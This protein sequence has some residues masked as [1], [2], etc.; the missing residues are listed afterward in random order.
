MSLK[1]RLNS[2]Q[3]SVL[4]ALVLPLVVVSALAIGTGFSVLQHNEDARLRDDVAL[5]GRA[6]SLPVSEAL[7]NADITAVQASLDA[8]FSIGRVHGAAV[9]DTR[10]QLVAAAGPVERDL[11]ESRL[12]ESVVR[13]GEQRD[14]YREVAGR[15]VFSR[16]FPLADRGGQIVGLLQVTRRARDFDNSLEQLQSL[17]WWVWLLLSATLTTVVVIGHKTAVGRH[18]QRLVQSMREVSAGAT[19]HRA[20]A[21][22]PNELREVAQCLNTMLDSINEAQRLA[23]MGQVARGVAHELGAP[24]TV[25]AGRAK[26]LQQQVGEQPDT[27]RQL[28]AITGQVNR[29]TT[30]VQQLLNFGRSGEQGNERLM[31][32]DVVAAACDSVQFEFDHRHIECDIHANAQRAAL[33]GN[34]ARLELALVNIL[35]NALQVA[36]Q[37]VLVSVVATPSTLTLRVIDDGPGLPN[38]YSVPQLLE[39][40]SSTKASGQGSGLGLAICAQVIADHHGRLQ[41]KNAPKGGCEVTIELPRAE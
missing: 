21:A 34:V 8:V 25:I 37:R 35:R 9:Y 3:A 30:L 32:T 31:I 33:H 24:L 11:T 10:G 4:L 28:M 12:A 40:F 27:Q 20:A 2:L 36:Q 41:L 7:L 5:L 22:G 38:N 19:E 29:L 6:I 1:Q 16:F 14:S 18:L 39:P 23:S 15:D 17:A 13:T 26:K